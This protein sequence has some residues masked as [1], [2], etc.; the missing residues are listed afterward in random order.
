ARFFFMCPPISILG[1]AEEGNHGAMPEGQ[2]SRAPG[3]AARGS[4]VGEDPGGGGGGGGPPAGAREPGPGPRA[5]GAPK[6]MRRK[7]PRLALGTSA[8]A[9]LEDRLCA[10]LFGQVLA[11]AGRE[12]LFR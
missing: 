4:S 11:Q 7:A 8:L 5:R 3:P 6:E 9:E 1:R 2:A 12:A 10:E